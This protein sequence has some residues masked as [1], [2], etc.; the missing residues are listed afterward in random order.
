MFEISGG[1]GSSEARGTVTRLTG[2]LFILVS[3]F[4]LVGSSLVVTSAGAST[5]WRVVSSGHASGSYA[6]AE[7]SGQGNS[8]KKIELSLRSKPALS[9]LVQRTMGCGTKSGGESD[10]SFKSTLKLPA[11]QKVK[12]PASSS[13]CIG[14]A[15]VQLG[16]FGKVTISIASSS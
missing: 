10:K 16:G 9:G 13:E 2:R 11:I 5:H 6:V 14:A 4:A 12:F 15:N 8:P 7:T 3:S 1:V